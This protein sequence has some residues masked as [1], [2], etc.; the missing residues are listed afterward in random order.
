MVFQSN[1]TPLIRSKQTSEMVGS[2]VAGAE[3]LTVR[4]GFDLFSEVAFLLSEGQ[5]AENARFPTLDNHISVLR[6]IMGSLE[7]PFVEV[8]PVPPGYDFMGCLTHDVDFVG[9]R[10]HKCDHTMWGFLYRSSVGSLL[11]ALAGRL[12]WSKCLQNWAAAFS[13]PLVHIGLLEDFWLE[14]D[15]Y[16][17]IEKEFGSTFFLPFKDVAGTLGPT[18][19]S[20]R[21]AAKYDLTEI[22]EQ[23]AELV[24]NGCEVGLHGIDAWQDV[25]SAQSERSRICQVTGQSN[26]G[27]RMHW[28]YWKESSPKTLEDAGFTYDSTFGYN[29]AVGFRAG[30][31]QPFRP[32]GAEHLLELPLNI[33]DSA[34]FYSNRMMLS[35]SEALD[36]CRELIHTMSLSGGAL[37]VNWHTRSLSPERLWGDFYVGLLK[38]IQSYRVWFGTAR[39]VVEWF[40]K[41]RALCFD[42]VEFEESGVRVALSS[43][44]LDSEFSFTLTIHHSKVDSDEV[45]M[46][47]CLPLHTDSPWN[48]GRVLEISY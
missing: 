12:P 10:D 13:L 3:H 26:L 15:R 28:L 44:D 30:T 7:V 22:K 40:R 20:N 45:A 9:V 35:E 31:T 4:I 34:M 24:R 14:F 18:P 27:T 1:G 48:R 39:Q 46:P 17:E 37:T 2:V 33:Q 8:P 42:S 32:L 43:P 29:D 36:A 19:A 21:R 6:T 5:P 38:E 47:L 25:Q 11:N 41:R 16:T 23:I